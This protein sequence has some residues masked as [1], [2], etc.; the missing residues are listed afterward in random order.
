M[1]TLKRLEMIHL[2]AQVSGDIKQY[3]LRH[4][5]KELLTCYLEKQRQ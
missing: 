1:R 3:V 4:I 5:C 2:I